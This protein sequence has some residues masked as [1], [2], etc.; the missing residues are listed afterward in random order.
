MQI[1][2]PFA[3]TTGGWNTFNVANDWSINF[4]NESLA[5]EATF[6]L[7]FSENGDN[8]TLLASKIKQYSELIF[9]V[10]HKGSTYAVSKQKFYGSIEKIT[11]H[12]GEALVLSCYDPIYFWSKCHVNFGT[13]EA[14][15]IKLSSDHL[16]PNHNPTYDPPN[17]PTNCISLFPVTENDETRWVIPSEID[18]NSMYGDAYVGTISDD[19]YNGAWDGHNFKA[20]SNRRTWKI[21]GRVYDS[22]LDLTAYGIETEYPEPVPNDFYHMGSD[23]VDYIEF[24]GYTPVGS[25]FVEFIVLYEEGTNQIEDIVMHAL[26]PEITGTITA[27]GTAT[28]LTSTLSDFIR[29]AVL[30][31]SQIYNSGTMETVDVVEVVD[32]NNLVTTPITGIYTTDDTFII[33]NGM[34]TTPRWRDTIHYETTGGYWGGQT[35]FPS[36]I[37]VNQFTWN[38]EDGSLL[39]MV[40]QL[41][42]ENAPPNYKI[43]FDH[44]IGKLR[45]QYVEQTPFDSTTPYYDD[46]YGKFIAPPDPDASDA[47]TNDF[48]TVYR[49]SEVHMPQEDYGFATRVIVEGVNKFPKNLVHISTQFVT[50]PPGLD[51]LNLPAGWN[52]CTET[53]PV[54][55]DMNKWECRATIDGPVLTYAQVYAAPGAMGNLLDLDASTG[56]YWM[57]PIHEATLKGFIPFIV[58]VL[59]EVTPVGK[60][61]FNAAQSLREFKWGLRIECCDVDGVRDDGMGQLYINK[62]ADWQLMHADFYNRKVESWEEVVIDSDFLTKEC[63]YILFSMSPV[64]LVDRNWGGVGAADIRIFKREIVT[65]EARIADFGRKTYGVCDNAVPENTTVHDAVA[66]FVTDGVAAGDE[67]RNITQDFVT[68]VDS[69]TNLNE[70]EAIVV[71]GKQWS[72]LDVYE[73]RD[74]A[75]ATGKWDYQLS[76]GIDDSVARVNLPILYQQVVGGSISDWGTPAGFISTGHRDYYYQDHSLSNSNACRRLA[77][78]ILF[79]TVREFLHGG[80]KIKWHNDLQ[81]YRTVQ[82][83][84]K[85]TGLS[86]KALVENLTLTQQGMS[87]DLSHTSSC[88]FTGETLEAVPDV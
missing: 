62:D 53:A 83:E 13:M 16:D 10:T 87:V 74:A 73:I 51:A 28:T 23:V 30:V 3:V 70:L 82:I 50:T 58:A 11:E 67:L 71:A 44:E 79:E 65:G 77:S 8:P 27:M 63:K 31:G 55:C 22:Q 36:Y 68:T 1:R 29:D 25:I 26:N 43:W 24:I 66:D 34:E 9:N 52:N 72:D 42:N 39:D 21:M 37:T 6:T 64:K 54:E 5:S 81:L 41:F 47:G 4:S 33:T 80:V 15:N 20:G 38:A 19:V 35:I 57:Y 40:E 59:D 49:A 84:D 85:R 86:K 69:V 75:K 60:I 18:G 7:K 46:A 78:K 17:D 2:T 14:H 45:M 88:T 61:V 32:R 76:T 56:I 48:H 12:G